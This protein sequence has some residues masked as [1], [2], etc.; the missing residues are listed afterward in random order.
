M[1][2]RKMMNRRS[3]K[4]LQKSIRLEIDGKMIDLPACEG[5]IILNILR[6]YIILLVLIFTQYINMLIVGLLEQIR[7]VKKRMNNFLSQRIMMEILK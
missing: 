6:F 4:D 7:G 1:G 5:I 2:L 3:C